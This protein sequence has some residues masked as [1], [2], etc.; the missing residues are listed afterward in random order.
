MLDVAGGEAHLEA[1]Q[2]DAAAPLLPRAQP[3]LEGLPAQR[4]RWEHAKHGGRAAQSAEWTLLC[5]L[6]NPPAANVR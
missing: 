1:N 6:A 4:S 5:P 3:N 2:L